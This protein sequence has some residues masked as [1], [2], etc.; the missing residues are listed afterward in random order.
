MDRLKMITDLP[1]EEKEKAMD[2]LTAKI[3]ANEPYRKGKLG[4]ETGTAKVT[5][6]V[7]NMSIEEARS[8]ADIHD[9]M[10]DVVREAAMKGK[11]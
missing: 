2:R 6:A 7:R 1:D 5:P 3:E 8:I 10:L 9:A 4:Q 11:G